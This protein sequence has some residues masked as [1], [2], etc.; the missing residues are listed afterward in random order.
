MKSGLFLLMPPGDPPRRA[1]VAVII[2]LSKTEQRLEAGASFRRESGNVAGHE[3]FG[4]SVGVSHEAQP[5]DFFTLEQLNG[6]RDVSRLGLTRAENPRLNSGTRPEQDEEL[7]RE[8]GF[9]SR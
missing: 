5:H 7:A 3:G 1:D 4:V 8:R 2:S 9:E 6:K